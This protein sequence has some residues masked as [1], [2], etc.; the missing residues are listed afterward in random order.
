MAET[1]VLRRH[2]G[3]PILTAAEFPQPVNSV[4]NA[5]VVK[6]EGQVL[7][8]N[9]VEDLTGS[10]CLWLARSDDG[11]HFIPDPEPALV[12]ATEEPYRSLEDCSLEDPRITQ[13]GDTFYVTYVAYSQYGCVTALA[14]TDD[15]ETYE[16]VAVMTV[17]D[18]KDIVLFPEKV[19]S[20]QAGK[21]YAK[22]DRPMTRP[23]SVGDMWISF[24][25]DLVYWGDPRPVMKPRPRKWDEYKIGG[26]APPIKTE[27]GWL[28]IY[29]G[30]RMTAAGALYRLGAVL[31]D[32][33]EPW[34]VIGRANEAILSP[35]AGEDFAGN[36]GN[37][38]FTCG[39]ILEDDGELTVYYG[40]AD[41]V[42]CLASAPV[43][44]VLA[45]CLKAA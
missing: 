16:R 1:H 24:S 13:I 41:Q 38:V 28:E 2:P 43:G 9:R 6:L 8:L 7:L 27:H 40:A 37:V 35:I 3:N 21:R 5:A 33:E 29:H 22:L 11:V 42:M 10:S 39:A 31:L 36:V 14:R 23:P 12:P 4:F 45:L 15:F 44:D 30:V 32:L 17:P 18:N 20:D 34:R 26:G 25:Q 19:G